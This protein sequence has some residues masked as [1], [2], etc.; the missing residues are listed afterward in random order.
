MYITGCTKSVS[1]RHWR[2]V[3]GSCRAEV[4]QWEEMAWTNLYY[5]WY[6]RAIET[7]RETRIFST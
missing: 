1:Y 2:N 5:E 6:M 4:L 7:P 3:I